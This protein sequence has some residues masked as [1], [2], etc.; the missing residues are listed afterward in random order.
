MDA[1]PREYREPPLARSGAPRPA[2]RTVACD[3]THRPRC[4]PGPLS[5]AC[6]GKA[7]PGPFRL[8]YPQLAVESPPAAAMARGPSW[9][10]SPGPLMICRPPLTGCRWCHPGRCYGVVPERQARAPRL[11]VRPLFLRMPWG[12]CRRSSPGTSRADLPG[13]FCKAKDARRAGRART[14]R[15]NCRTFFPTPLAHPHRC[16]G[17]SESAFFRETRA[18][19]QFAA[20]GLAR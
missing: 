10:S 14:R 11:S 19:A 5:G 15:R 8:S 1:G 4:C 6:T 13:C 3:R 17:G 2:P 20:T 12:A 9:L 7:P 16:I 18:A